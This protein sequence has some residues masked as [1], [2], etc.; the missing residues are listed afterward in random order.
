MHWHYL[1]T[2]RKWDA[3]IWQE[4][5]FTAYK[6]NQFPHKYRESEMSEWFDSIKFDAISTSLARNKAENFTLLEPP[7][8]S[9]L[10]DSDNVCRIVHEYTFTELITTITSLLNS[11]MPE[12]ASGTHPISNPDAHRMRMSVYIFVFV[13]FYK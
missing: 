12:N 13:S 7:L 10:T 6:I 9:F 4:H 2:K 11:N 8:N 3:L 1:Y 5:T